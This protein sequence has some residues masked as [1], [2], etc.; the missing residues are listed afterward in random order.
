MPKKSKQEEKEEIELAPCFTTKEW[1]VYEKEKEIFL[2]QFVQQHSTFSLGAERP[3][4]IVCQTSNVEKMV[5]EWMG[6]LLITTSNWS[7]T[8][9]SPFASKAFRETFSQLRLYSGKTNYWGSSVKKDVKY[10]LNYARD[11]GVQTIAFFDPYLST[12]HGL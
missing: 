11:C 8:L 3:N 6:E 10:S 1:M 9:P 7:Y 2:Q 5:S 12:I 4:L